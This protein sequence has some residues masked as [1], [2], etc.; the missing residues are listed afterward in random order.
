MACDFSCAIQV[1]KGKPF[2]VFPKLW[3]QWGVTKLCYEKDFEPYALERDSKIDELAK[4]EGSFSFASCRHL[5]LAASCMRN[6][7]RF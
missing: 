3:K 6:S 7:K 1:L 2:E 4:K 5:K